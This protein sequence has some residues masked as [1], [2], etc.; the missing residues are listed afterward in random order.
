MIQKLI[1]QTVGT[2]TLFEF[3]DSARR[4]LVKNFGESDIYVSFGTT[5]PASQSIKI[6]SGMA[7]ECEI[8]TETNAVY[9]SGDGEVEIQEEF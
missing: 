4:F 7:Q 9:V 5:A 1:R 6:A 2:D 8:H 3:S